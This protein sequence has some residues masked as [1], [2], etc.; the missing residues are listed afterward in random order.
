M[1]SALSV[2]EAI[3][4]GNRRALELMLAADPVLVDVVPAWKAI[5]GL[6][7]H[8]ILHAGPPIEWQRMCGP[9]RGAVAGVAVYEGCL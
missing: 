6:S 5:D 2:A 7:E 9:M 8:T 1:A 3:R 4:A